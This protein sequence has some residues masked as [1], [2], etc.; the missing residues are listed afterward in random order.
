[1]QIAEGDCLYVWVSVP[2]PPL[3][4]ESCYWMQTHT[5][6]APSFP[7]AAVEAECHAVCVCARGLHLVD[8][9]QRSAHSLDGSGGNLPLRKTHH[10][11]VSGAYPCFWWTP[12]LLYSSILPPAVLSSRPA[13]STLHTGWSMHPWHSTH[14]KFSCEF[15]HSFTAP[16]LTIGALNFYSQS[17]LIWAQHAM[18]IV[19][20]CCLV[21]A[22]VCGWVCVSEAHTYLSVCRCMGRPAADSRTPW[23]RFHANIELLHLWPL[24]AVYNLQCINSRRSIIKETKYQYPHPGVSLVN[25]EPVSSTKR[26]QITTI[27]C[28]N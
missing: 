11:T 19:L 15:I 10:C 3:P 2:P 26:Y 4:P 8:I 16:L 5:H 24:K 14:L 12:P 27:P 9:T 23:G 18:C 7:L 1:M 22:W 17:V 21:C 6:G 13:H 28:S 20:V 25:F